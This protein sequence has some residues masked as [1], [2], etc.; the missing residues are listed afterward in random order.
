VGVSYHR[1]MSA[2]PRLSPPPG[3]P[4]RLLGSPLFLMLQLVRLARRRGQAA[5]REP[6]PIRLPHYSVLAVLTDL[7]PASQREVAD[8]LGFDASDL[9][10]VV[11]SLEADG[12]L[13]RERDEADRRRHILTV[14]PVG[15]SALVKVEVRVAQ[16]REDFLAPL[17]AAERVTLAE[18][19]RRLYTHHTRLDTHHVRP[20]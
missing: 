16:A 10:G 17:S 2:A 1:S 19:L 14:T 3:L 18:L 15:R 13:T 9:V 11:D 5:P 6:G 4:E 12:C 20:D 7:G 8:A